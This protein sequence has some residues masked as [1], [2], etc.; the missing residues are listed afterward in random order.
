VSADSSASKTAGRPK[1][2]VAR[3]SSF[4]STRIVSQCEL[5]RHTLAQAQN[6]PVGPAWPII[7]LNSSFEIAPNSFE[8][9][10]PPE[11]HDVF[12]LESSEGNLVGQ[13]S[14]LRSCLPPDMPSQFLILS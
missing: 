11:P 5:S 2:E 9:T 10:Q 3:V 12:S 13:S 14:D 6:A 4:H 8:S 7:H 1:P